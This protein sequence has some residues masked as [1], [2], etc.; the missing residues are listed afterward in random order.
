MYITLTMRQI[1]YKSTTIQ[2]YYSF[3]T[4]RNSRTWSEAKRTLRKS[5]GEGEW[6]EFMTVN[7]AAQS[8]QN[9]NFQ[10]YSIG[11]AGSPLS[12]CSFQLL[13][14]V[15]F[16]EGIARVSY[17]SRFDASASYNFM[18]ESS[19]FFLSSFY[20]SVSLI[21]CFILLLLF[22]FSLFFKVITFV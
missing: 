8:S 16:S 18:E 4:S 19:P 2:G 13:A 10:Y 11:A 5:N 3:R 21:Y 1:R 20:C 9:V 12:H 7:I 6:L 22:F 15:K 17:V 14:R